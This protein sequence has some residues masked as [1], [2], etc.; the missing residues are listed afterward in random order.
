MAYDEKLAEKVQVALKGKRGVTEK[1]MFGGI[2][3]LINGKMIGG[4]NKDNLLLRVGPEKQKEALK[5]KYARP[6]DFTGRKMT[7]FV[8]MAADGLKRS[9]SMARWIGLGL[10]YAGSLPKKKK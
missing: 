7:G 1:K 3:F 5:H 8:H 9:D 2:C 4:V 6:I 10:D